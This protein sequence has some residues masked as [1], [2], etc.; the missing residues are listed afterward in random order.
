MTK[1]RLKQFVKNRGPYLTVQLAMVVISL[2]AIIFWKDNAVALSIACSILASAIVGL[3]TV[4]FLY[5]EEEDR[6]VIKRWGLTNI[7]RS[8]DVMNTDCDKDLRK[9]REHIDYVGFGFRSLRDMESDTIRERLAAGAKIRF[10]VMSPDCPYLEEREKEEKCS[11]GEIKKS[12]HDLENWVRELNK[13]NKKNN[14]QLRY[15]NTLPLDYYNRIDNVVYM[16]P[17]WYNKTSQ[18]TVSYKFIAGSEGYNLYTDYFDDLWE[19]KELTVDALGRRKGNK[20]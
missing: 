5:Q 9:A 4:S 2:V 12:I 14:I 8:R 11:P 13:E 7:Y 15:Y 18:H 3:F 16:G 20:A 10:L 6:E 17:Y 1:N 19:D